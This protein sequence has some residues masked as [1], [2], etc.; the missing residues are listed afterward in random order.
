MSGTAKRPGTFDSARAKEAAKKRGKGKRRMSAAE[1]LAYDNLLAILKDEAAPEHVKQKAA[2]V[3]LKYERGTPVSAAAMGTVE[4]LQDAL[5]GASGV[6][7]AYG[8]LRPSY[9]PT[10]DMDALRAKVERLAQSALPPNF[11]RLTPEQRQ[12]LEELRNIAYGG[13]PPAVISEDDFPAPV[14]VV[15]VPALAVDPVEQMKRELEAIGPSLSD[16]G[17][18]QAFNPPA[19]PDAD[20]ADRERACQETG[21]VTGDLIGRRRQ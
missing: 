17:R 16:L 7:G 20:V 3:V 18:Q 9:R 13:S 2:E 15:V 11:D 5:G 10:V 4:P 14:D 8:A 21:S 12:Q 6:A 1:K 19:V